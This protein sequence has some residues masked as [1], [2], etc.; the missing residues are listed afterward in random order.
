VHR[1]DDHV[2]ICP[3]VS[4]GD[5]APLDQV[6]WCNLSE[7]RYT[8]D[9]SELRQLL[10]NE[11]TKGL[12]ATRARLE[13]IICPEVSIKNASS[14]E[15]VA[16]LETMTASNGITI[17]WPEKIPRRQISYSAKTISLLRILEALGEQLGLQMWI[18]GNKVTFLAGPPTK[19]K[20][21]AAA[22]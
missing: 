1:Q 7:D 6:Y 21:H 20:D 2:Y 22:H 8:S 16:Y 4:V 19:A 10:I 15:I 5:A 12:D 17:E 9:S 3:L 18:S 11:E 13:K 14:K